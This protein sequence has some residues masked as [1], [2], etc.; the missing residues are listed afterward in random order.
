MAASDIIL[1]PNKVIVL[2][3]LQNNY[4]R[5]FL[6]TLCNNSIVKLFNFCKRTI[7]TKTKQNNEPC[8]KHSTVIT[9]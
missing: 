2:Q 8:L 5:F 6:E 4:V 7:I 1:L 9:K 3:N